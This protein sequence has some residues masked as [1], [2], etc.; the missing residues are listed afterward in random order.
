MYVKI[1]PFLFHFFCSLDEF[2]VMDPKMSK[3]MKADT[4][5]SD[6]PFGNNAQALRTFYEDMRGYARSKSRSMFTRASSV[7]SSAAAIAGGGGVGGGVDLGDAAT[8]YG[9]A[10]VGAGRAVCVCV[11]VF[12]GYCVSILCVFN[13]AVLLMTVNVKYQ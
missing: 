4:A 6:E 5:P 10:L 7:S 1:F 9:H 2:L 13:V 8:P 11:F 3:K 12:A